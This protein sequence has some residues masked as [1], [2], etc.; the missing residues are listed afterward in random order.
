[1]NNNSETGGILSI[2][3]GAIGTVWAIL[4]FLIATFFN[5]ISSTDYYFQITD[6]TDMLPIIPTVCGTLGVILL[7][8][9]IMAINNRRRIF[10]KK[11]VMGPCPC[12]SYL[13]DS[14]VRADMHSSND[15]G[16]SWKKRIQPTDIA[17]FIGYVSVKIADF[18][19]VSHLY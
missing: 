1:M 6:G 3:S 16:K 4:L 12:R 8:F 14:G 19:A 15:P 5:A 13:W 9:A 7:I 17:H 2:V 18:T 11:E 10:Y